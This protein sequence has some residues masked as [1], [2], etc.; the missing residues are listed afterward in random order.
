M[1]IDAHAHLVVR[2]W[3]PDSYWQGLA[4]IYSAALGRM[5]TPVPP[6]AV[7]AMLFPQL[8]DPTD[9]KTL[10]VMDEAGIE[11]KVLLPLD[12]GLGL[13]EPAVDYLTRNHEILSMEMKSRPSWAA[14]LVGST[15]FNG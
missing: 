12:L 14:Q 9:E 1:T 4:R 10:A 2:E 3:Y 6:E 15:G 7:E 5:G 8:F 13:G 11:V